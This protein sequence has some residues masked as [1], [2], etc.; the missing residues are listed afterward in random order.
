MMRFDLRAPGPTPMADLYDAALD[1]AEW[2]DDK[3]CLAVVLSQHHASDDGFLPSPLV[4]AGAMA[5]RTQVAPI[6][7]AA[8]LLLM[9]DP[10]KLAEDL[11]VL[12]HLSRGRLSAVIGL[13]YRPEE[14]AMFGVDP[15]GRGAEMEERLTVLRQAMAGESVSWRGRTVRVRPEPFTAGGASLSYGGSSPAAARRA[16]RFGL[17]LISESDMPELVEA[18]EA[19]AARLGTPAGGCI[20]PSNDTPTSTFVAEDPDRAWA[21][22]GSH[23]LHDAQ[24]YGAWLSDE[25]SPVSRST[26]TTVEELRAE[27]G[28]YRI[29]TPEEAVGM[30]QTNGY[31]ATQP[32]CGGMDPALAWESLELIVSDVLPKL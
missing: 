9:Y 12:D 14:F 18:Y 21:R 4:M 27:Q 15:A 19:E 16:A 3:G 8:L 29:V 32:L 5:A 26:A 25:H 2:A 28:N 7:I 17:P 22:L 23:L 31:L 30:V 24:A 1:M 10:I 11:N 13:G 6:N 20:I